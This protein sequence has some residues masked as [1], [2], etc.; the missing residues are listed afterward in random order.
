MAEVLAIFDLEG[1][2]YAGGGRIIWRE[3]IKSRI[4]GRLIA[5]KVFAHVLFQLLIDLL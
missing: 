4:R 1:T 3:I 2:L 5:G